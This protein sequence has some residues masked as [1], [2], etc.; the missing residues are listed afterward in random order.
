MIGRQV[1]YDPTRVAGIFTSGDTFCNLYGYLLSIRKAFRDSVHRGIP[2]EQDYRFIHSI[3]GHYSNVTAL[4]TLGT[5][6]QGKSI[7]IKALKDNTVD[8]DNL[9]R[10]LDD[11]FRLN[12]K[13]PCILLTIGTTDTFGVDDPKK[14]YNIRDK[15]IRKYGLKDDW[16]P[17]LHCDAA[18]GWPMMFFNNYNLEENPI[19]LNIKTLEVIAQH[20]LHTVFYNVITVGDHSGGPSVCWRMYK[21]INN[22]DETETAFEHDLNMKFSDSIDALDEHTVFHRQIHDEIQA[23]H[24]KSREAGLSLDWIGYMLTTTYDDRGRTIY[25]PG[26]KAVFFKCSYHVREH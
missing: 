13:V 11:C 2:S 9:E 1:E 23:M 4:S 22:H 15:M 19:G 25:T 21:G 20:R 18:V 8:W 12:I 3:S 6:I 5:D 14:A 7:S 17:H 26:Q 16:I 24:T 10:Q